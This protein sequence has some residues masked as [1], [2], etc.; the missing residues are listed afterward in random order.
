M[1]TT[2]KGELIVLDSLRAGATCP[3]CLLAIQ[4]G[5]TAA[6]CNKCG[7]LN[8]EICWQKQGCGSYHCQTGSSKSFDN[9]ATDIVIT[10]ADVE[11]LKEIPAN[12]RHGTAA[13]AHEI[14][15]KQSAGW[16]PLSIVA[17]V[18]GIGTLTV[19]V[20]NFSMKPAENQSLYFLV[21][22][23]GCLLSILIGA[24]S[25]AT[26]QN[27]STKKGL[28]FSFAGMG[29][30]IL[31]MILTMYPLMSMSE[32]PAE[33]FKL[34]MK[35]VAETIRTATPSIRGPLMANV[36]IKA[37]SGYRMGMGSGIALCNRDAFTYILS[38]AHVLTLG[39]SANNLQE[40]EKKAGNVEVTFYSGETVNATPI[41]LAPDKID[42]VL[43][44]VTTPQGFVPALKYQRGRPILMGQRVFAVGNPI[45]L[46]WTYTDG[47]I[48]AL[49]TNRYGSREITVVQIQAPLNPGNS[50]GG[51]YDL[52]GYLIG[53][54]TWIY[55]KSVTEGLNFS[56]SIDEFFQLLEPEWA[57]VLALPGS[58]QLAEK[59]E[60]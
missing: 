28:L 45:G 37:G 31:A 59:D 9:S 43:L 10:K 24:I 35:Q 44:R 40:L 51:L 26:F 49:R 36:H 8:H 54:N 2:N 50:G 12:S 14:A 57:E 60:Q 33:E 13:I 58:S 19:C 22:L 7:S 29:S 16:A 5:E 18:I 47:V 6:L 21:A 41:W 20:V 4:E 46:N 30:G 53:V 1:N 34:N 27:N 38:N 52:D 55:S 25:I 39:T 11:S 23:G 48:S 17:L 3:T 56:I 15:R 32:S 42:L